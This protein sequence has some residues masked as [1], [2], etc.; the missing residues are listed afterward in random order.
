MVRAIGIF[1][2]HRFFVRFCEKCGVAIFIRNYQVNKNS[3]AN[4][5]N[6]H[7]D[8]AVEDSFGVGK[9]GKVAVKVSGA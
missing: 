3:A 1:H 5:G 9:L 2:L 4:C 6:I 8:Y 7:K